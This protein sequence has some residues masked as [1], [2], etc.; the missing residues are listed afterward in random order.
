MGEMPSCIFWFQGV[1]P[2]NCEGVASLGSLRPS[3]RRPEAPWSFSEMHRFEGE[4]ASGDAVDS[5]HEWL[6]FCI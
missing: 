6:P 4:F 5:G 2:G 1:L 3:G